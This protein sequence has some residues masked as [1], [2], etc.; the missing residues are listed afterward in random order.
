MIWWIT[1]APRK[2]CA[3]Q[4]GLGG[5]ERHDDLV[6]LVEETGA[7]LAGQHADHPEGLAV[8]ADGL[9]DG[10]GGGAKQ[11]FGHCAAQHDHGGAGGLVRVGDEGPICHGRSMY[12]W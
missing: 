11:G 2:R 4:S 10:P 6:I 9:P 5:R 3:Y 12:S 1:L 7:A 8:Q